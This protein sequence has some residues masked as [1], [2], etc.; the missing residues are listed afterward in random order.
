MGC[1]TFADFPLPLSVGTHSMLPAIWS[2]TASMP[3]FNLGPSREGK[4]LSQSFNRADTHQLT[5]DTF[6]PC[7]TTITGRLSF[8]LTT[9]DTTHGW[10]ISR[11]NV[12]SRYKKE[13]VLEK[14]NNGGRSFEPL[15]S[16]PVYLSEEHSYYD[17]T[18]QPC[19]ES[20]NNG[21]DIFSTI[22]ASVDMYR[23]YQG[24]FIYRASSSSWERQPD[25][26]HAIRT[27]SSGKL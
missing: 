2:V 9:V 3:P 11:W 1:L 20:L 6:L 25:I 23:G 8:H 14:T 16:L 27:S 26:R 18:P 5:F 7:R 12:T 15:P 4:N 22:F 10:V 13:Y 21:G 19:L 17:Y 24:A